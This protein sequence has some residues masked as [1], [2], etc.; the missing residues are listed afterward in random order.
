MDTTPTAVQRAFFA[1]LVP[2]LHLDEYAFHS[3]HE[4]QALCLFIDAAEQENP[5]LFGHPRIEQP[6][7]LSG[8]NDLI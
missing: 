2:T 7:R 6:I 8:C 4:H 5:R 1:P 3:L